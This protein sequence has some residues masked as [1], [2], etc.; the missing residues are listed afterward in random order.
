MLNKM[1]LSVIMEKKRKFFI[2]S[3]LI[4]LFVTQIAYSLEKFSDE[5]F[6]SDYLSPNSLSRI[7]NSQKIS[8]N[9]S[10]IT[11]NELNQNSQAYKENNFQNDIENSNLVNEDLNI[12]DTKSFWALDLRKDSDNYEE[13]YYQ[14]QAT[15]VAISQYSYIFVETIYAQSYLGE[16]GKGETLASSF[17]QIYMKE[18]PFFGN[19]SD[20]DNNGKIIILVLDIPNIGNNVAGFFS[21]LNWFKNSSNP[22][23]IDFYSNYAD[24]IYI[25]KDFVQSSGLATLA[26]EFQHL[27]QFNTDDSED[28]WLDEGLSMYAEKLTGYDNTINDYIKNENG[29]FGYNIDLSLTY[30]EYS[31]IAHYGGA[32]L[33]LLYLSD[34]FGSNFVSQISRDNDYQGMKSIE[35]NLK[36]ENLGINISEVFQDWSISLAINNVNSSPY[37]FKNYTSQ[38]SIQSD[39]NLNELK[40][41]F[42][43]KVDHWASDIIDLSSTPPG[44][45]WISFHGEISKWENE[46]DREYSATV[47]QYNLTN[48]SWIIKKMNILEPWS[49]EINSSL[50]MTLLIINSI[51]GTSS[52]YYEAESPKTWFSNYNLYGQKQISTL[53]LITGEIK[54]L[55]TSKIIIPMPKSQNGTNWS[56]PLLTDILLQVHDVKTGNIIASYDAFNWDNDLGYFYIDLDLSLFNPGDYYFSAKI[57]SIGEEIILFSKGWEELSQFVSIDLLSSSDRS[58][59]TSNNS[60]SIY[61]FSIFSFLFLTSIVYLKRRRNY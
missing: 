45:Y 40:G 51:T 44:K 17:D 20:R 28:V 13:A 47:V 36:S 14:L 19:P 8:T 43:K 29:G 58:N 31:N 25:E 16:N 37:F 2:L 32:Y 46:F 35:N 30:W 23:E 24:M 18:V 41:L 59:N 5:D 54:D 39:W 27:I 42:G 12:N 34:R 49:I 9:E 61:G 10:L 4:L 55:S 53:P 11:E 56:I 26:H 1:D 3:L 22:E 52:G 21:P 7:E 50:T 48:S 57:S 33:F 15:V 6:K 38:V 60:N